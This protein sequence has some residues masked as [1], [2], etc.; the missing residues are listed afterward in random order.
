MNP[1]SRVLMA[2]AFS[3]AFA[4]AASAAESL[5]Q[6]DVFVS[7]EG[8]YHTYRIPVLV[9]TPKGTLLAFCEG[10]K[11]GQGDAGDIDLLLRR[12]TDGGATWGPVQ[13]VWDDGPNT[14]GNPCPVVDRSSHTIWLPVTRG[15]GKDTEAQILAGTSQGSKTLWMMKSEDEGETWSDP[16]DITASVKAPDWTWYVAGPG[17]G[18]QLVTGRLVIPCDHALAGSK[19]YGAHVIY[20]DDR[21]E[22]WKRGGSIDDK[23]NECQVAERSDGTL[24]LNMRSYHG[25][26]CRAV[27]TSRD[28]GE[29]WSAITHDA[30][31][32]EPVCQAALVTAPLDTATC[33]CDRLLFANPASRKRENLTVRLSEDGGATWTTSKVLHAG[34]AA[35]SALAVLKDGR[36]C[37]LYE[38]GAKNPYERITLARF[39]MKDLKE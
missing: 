6:T 15:L 1:K 39:P 19:T 30:A 13:V 20:S 28:G 32:V 4:T 7:S 24:L 3:L 29:T 27:A 33:A 36:V 22:T 35:Y 21:G 18:I 2:A 12:S 8:G 31:L 26:G 11:G 38:R 10:R 5:Q 25:K 16:V 14:V 23:V 37:C 17:C 9:V 34:P